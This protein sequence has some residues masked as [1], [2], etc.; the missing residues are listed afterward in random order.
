[1]TKNLNEKNIKQIPASQL[2]SEDEIISSWKGDVDKPFVSINCIT[3]NHAPY[4]ED[5]L[6]GFLR[7]ETEFPIEIVIHDDAST[8]GTTDIIK[9]YVKLYPKLIKP[10]YQTENQYSMGRRPF[11]LCFE[12]AKGELIA[13]CEGDDYWISSV[14]LQSQVDAFYK[15]EDVGL[16]INPAYVKGKRQKCSAKR[17]YYGDKIW[18]FSA[19]D[20]VNNPDQF[21]PTSS[22][23]FSRKVIDNFPSWFSV[24]PVGD[25]FIEL[26]ALS[27]GK[28]IYLPNIDCV[29]RE[30]VNNS[31]T[32][33]GRYETVNKKLN[34]AIRFRK[35]FANYQLDNPQDYFDQSNRESSMA[36]IIAKSY[37]KE[38]NYKFF[39]HH[40][41]RSWD[42][43]KFNSLYQFILFVTSYLPKPIKYLVSRLLNIIY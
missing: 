21:A 29:Y 13:T 19:H 24:T 7:Q 6:V 41:R 39:C 33:N 12:K 34:K 30:M 9:K 26:L 23:L 32:F 43:K 8:D 14:K 15:Y 17:W 37:L 18:F 5:A 27:N 42:L 22:Y 3:Y 4:I 40:I 16:V 2:R 10:I 20:V 1:M 38:E 35:A 36:Y 11:P 25:T 31:H 28:G